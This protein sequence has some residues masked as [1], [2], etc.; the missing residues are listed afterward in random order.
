[1]NK[2]INFYLVALLP[3][4]FSFQV[5]AEIHFCG[6]TGELVQSDQP[7]EIP[8]TNHNL[9]PIEADSID[10]DSVNATVDMFRKA[11]VTRDIHAV[12]RFLADD[13]VFLSHE[14]DWNGKELFNADKRGFV[15][16]MRQHLLAMTSYRQII[17]DYSVKTILDQLTAETISIEKVELGSQEIEAKL[18]ERMTFV[19]VEDAL[20]IRSIKQIELK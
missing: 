10:V 16:L 14:K 6:M 20:K 9:K 13:F 3:L 7:C 19:T 18:L 17:E 11:T 8:T 15:A 1:M 12:E 2:N 5:S 4:V